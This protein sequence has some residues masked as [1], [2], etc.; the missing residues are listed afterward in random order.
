MNSYDMIAPFTEPSIL[1]YAVLPI[2]LDIAFIIGAS[3]RQA[4]DI[5][6]RQKRIVK[7]I[8]NFY[9]VS[10]GKTHIGIITRSNP[11]V[12]NLEIGQIKKRSLLYK[13]LDQIE[14]PEP[15]NHANALAVAN[16][17][18]FSPVYGARPDFRKSLIIFVDGYYEE[19]KAALSS[20]AKK[21][22]S[23]GVKVIVIDS[24]SG[25]DP[26]LSD[27]DGRSYD[28]F[29]FPPSLDELELALYPVVTAMQPGK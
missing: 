26:H 8:L 3:V 1:F 6:R 7:E 15:G 5:L 2:D 12:I 10:S 9:D 18:V 11:S 20:V 29:F 23:Q 17:G 24:S 25:R 4:N 21:M 14:I 16:N 22:E 27:K 19:D 28:V 13:H